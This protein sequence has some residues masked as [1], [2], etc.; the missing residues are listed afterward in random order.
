MDPSLASIT[1]EATQIIYRE[2]VVR[3]LRDVFSE[4]YSDSWPKLIKHS[5]GNDEWKRNEANVTGRLV[6]GELKAKPQ[7]DFDL[8]GISHFPSL[9]D[10]YYA[11]LF[12]YKEAKTTREAARIRKS[13]LNWATAIATFAEPATSQG[14]EDFT[15]RLAFRMID[16]AC[17]VLDALDLPESIQLRNIIDDLSAV[18]STS[19]RPV[20][21]EFSEPFHLS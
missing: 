11:A 13:I 12:P 10:K 16:S 17:H 4:K 2:A 7:D 21:M 5:I 8:L 6:S 3:H 18:V 20:V 9:F 1:Y 15:F 19:L 14:K